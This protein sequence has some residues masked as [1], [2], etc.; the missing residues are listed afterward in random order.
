MAGKS[1][2]SSEQILEL[3]SRHAGQ[4][5]SLRDVQAALDLSAGERKQ[6]GKLVKEL[7]REKLLRRV[8][9]GR[10]VMPE[11]GRQITGILSVHRDGYGFVSRGDDQE[12][13]F[14]PARFLK[15]AMH[16]DRVVIRLERD[17]RTGRPEGHVV[18][19]SERAHKT[20]VGQYQRFQNI[21]TVL[22]VDPSLTDEILVPS[23]AEGDAH[24][25]QM[26]IVQIESYPGRTRSAVGK[27]IEVL[28]D[29]DDPAVEIRVT[30]VKYE[31]PIEFSAEAMAEAGR[32][33]D[34]VLEHD[35]AG[36]RDL[37][38]LP[39]V[40]IDGETAKDFDDAVAI[41]R[42]SGGGYRL[43]VAI[44]DVSH[45][46]RPKSALDCDAFERGTSVY[47]PGD[48]IPMLPESL[49]NGICSLNPQ[50]DRLVVVAELDFDAR[51]V[52]V[53]SRFYSGVIRS[54]TRLTYTEVRLMLVDQDEETCSR[55]SE[56]LTDLQLM[57][58]F[59]ELR[60]TRRRERGSLDF[61][62]PTAEIVLDLRGRPENVVRSERNLAHRLI[63]EMMLAANEAVAQWLERQKVPLIFR[64]HESPGEEKMALLQDFIAHFNQGV[65]IPAEGVT[66]K[67][68]Q[69][70]LNRVAGRPE[71]RV[72]NHVLLRSLPQAVYDVENHGH[73]GLAADSY[74]HFTSPIRRYPDLMVHRVL[75]RH[76]GLDRGDNLSVADSLS[77]IAGKS[78]VCE[79]RAMEAERDI[80]NLK[81]CQFMSERIG[82]IY[83]GL[84]V[85][86]Q[87]FGFFVELEE[88][89]VEGLVHVNSLDDDFYQYEEETQRL[90]G[91]RQRRKFE[92]G[93]QV[94]V[95]VQKADTSRR[96]ISF[97]LKEGNPVARPGRS[98]RP[99]GRRRRTG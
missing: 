60:I 58:S 12:D 20:L 2:V 13:V 30:A 17:P 39:F 89:F 79:R 54:R 32:V 6:V 66:P 97:L 93:D 83:R 18:S 99:S 94:E 65:S 98:R 25:G 14:I 92:I 75:K 44:A 51:G 4:S 55:Y 23:G 8:K 71:E 37:R 50:E 56:F 61:D 35:L 76:L 77:E 43:W 9:G 31:L 10:F 95:L 5:L 36:R 28:G 38:S 59:S 3:F 84:I 68:L 70:L 26:V 46:V 48:C 67:I 45:Y 53:Q 42:Q 73:F 15:P 24:H 72:I 82:E 29:A 88:Y 22:V 16:G 63:E 62:L 27:V 41:Q 11:K 40:T 96:E 47:F 49:S 21:G 85:S 78:S 64:V 91:M 86:I 90:I 87:P 74:C 69:D 57:G 33:P 1:E 34:R 19:V 7:V 81:K 52:R 80:L